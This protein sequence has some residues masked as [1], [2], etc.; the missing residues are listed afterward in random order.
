[1]HTAGQW[2]FV[3]DNLSRGERLLPETL[4]FQLIFLRQDAGPQPASRRQR[5]KGTKRLISEP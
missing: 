1:M 2:I 4:G 3:T 5:E